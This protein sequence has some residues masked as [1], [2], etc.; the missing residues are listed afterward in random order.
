MPVPR[1]LANELS[2]LCLDVACNVRIGALVDGH[3]RGGV[4]HEYVANAI[5]DSR[6]PDYFCHLV[7]DVNQLHPPLA[8]DPNRHPP[9]LIRVGG[10][11]RRIFS[12]SKRWKSATHLLR[13]TGFVYWGVNACLTWLV[14][15]CRPGIPLR[16]RSTE[17]RWCGPSWPAR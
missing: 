10:C 14:A 5:R 17:N 9:H 16:R 8:L 15:S 4:L 7:G 6:T 3:A 13:S 1:I 12:T 11:G 2:Q